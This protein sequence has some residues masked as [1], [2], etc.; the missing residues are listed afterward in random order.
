MDTL[1]SKE[2]ILRAW[3]EFAT[4]DPERVASVF[5]ADAEWLAP[6]GNATARELDGTHHLVGRDRLVQFLTVEFPAVFAADRQVDFRA[7]TAADTTV[8]VE[9]RMRAT[10]RNGQKYDNDYCFVFEVS[11]GLITRVREYMDT[12]RA[13]EM[14]A[15]SGV[16]HR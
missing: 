16:P 10:L 4:L 8:V 2:L 14:F 3:R 15:A 13:E 5:A 12:R 6:P 1:T 9:T 11:D 7:V